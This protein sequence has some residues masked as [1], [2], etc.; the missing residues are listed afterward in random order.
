[1]L[2]RKWHTLTLNGSAALRPLLDPE[3][4]S[5]ACAPCG[6]TPQQ[7]CP[8]RTDIVWRSELA[9]GVVAMKRREFVALAAIL[10]AW[11]LPGRSQQMAKVSRVALI[12]QAMP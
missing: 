5:S 10:A 12:A 6:A 9:L 1:M 3:E 2:V 7:P 11:P 8:L 4:T